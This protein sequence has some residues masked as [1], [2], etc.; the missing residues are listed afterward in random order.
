MSFG[1]G[2]EDWAVIVMTGEFR[3]DGLPL[4]SVAYGEDPELPGTKEEVVGRARERLKRCTKGAGDFE[5]VRAEPYL[6]HQRV[7]AQARKGRVLLAGGA[8][9]S[10][11]PIGGLGLTGGILY[12]YCYGN[13]LREAWLKPTDPTWTTN[14]KCISSDKEEDVKA[15][16][17]FFAKLNTDPGFRR[18]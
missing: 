4:W 18:W 9:H 12:A 5:I 7:A 3:E 11:N 6:M 10:S 15:Q 14:L 2:R 8:L 17:G 16:K 1:V 13:A